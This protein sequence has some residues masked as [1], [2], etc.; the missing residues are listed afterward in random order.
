MVYPILRFL[1]FTQ[2]ASSTHLEEFGF[3]KAD[4]PR[5]AH[6]VSGCWLSTYCVGS[7]SQSNGEGVW[8]HRSGNHTVEIVHVAIVSAF[9]SRLKSKFFN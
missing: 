4:E 1:I 9:N 6:I 2:L 3:S 7:L 8:Q 5:G